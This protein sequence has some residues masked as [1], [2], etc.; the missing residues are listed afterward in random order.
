MTT[1]SI[2]IL[3][4]ISHLPAEGDDVPSLSAS[5]ADG[6]HR[7]LDFYGSVIA[8]GGL[9]FQ[10]TPEGIAPVGESSLFLQFL[11]VRESG[12][13]PH[14]DLASSST[15][16]NLSFEHELP[17]DASAGPE[18]CARAFLEHLN[19]SLRHAVRGFHG[20]P[21]PLV[22][23][24]PLDNTPGIAVQC[25][26]V[27]LADDEAMRTLAEKC[28]DASLALIFESPEIEGRGLREAI[29]ALAIAGI[30]LGS[31]PTAEAGLFSRRAK[32]TQTEKAS[33]K[34]APNLRAEVDQ[35]ILNQAA[36]GNTHV[37]ID[38][39]KQRAYLLV[40]G[41]VAI[42]TPVSTA[43]AGKYTP[44]G[45]FTITQKVRS[46]KTSTIY[47][48]DLPCWMR[49]D[50]SPIGLHVGDLPGYPA[51]AGCVRLPSNIAPL[52]FDHAPSGT[53]VKIVNSVDVES[54]AK[55]F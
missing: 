51:S 2:A 20:Q 5:L 37:L 15:E 26:G 3:A 8:D 10:V 52:I 28:D 36:S 6:P 50:D 4:P 12:E 39:S 27:W 46:G 30:F 31:I 33:R 55:A 42:D 7:L 43:R 21:V 9:H 29:T 49:L 54:Y 14:L 17:L 16:L 47:G 18:D 22:R 32:T 24:H 13:N 25:L 35:K 53:V 34:A 41:Q 11:E 45:E 23:W 19:A 38:V 48:C 44:R 40:N 1:A